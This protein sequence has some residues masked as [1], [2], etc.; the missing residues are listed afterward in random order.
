MTDAEISLAV[1]RIMYP[2]HGW[3]LDGVVYRE[4]EDG[5]LYFFDYRSKDKA[6]G[7]AVWLA[8][9]YHSGAHP[10]GNLRYNAKINSS[11]F[12]SMFE[13]KDPQRALADAIMEVGNER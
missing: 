2:E 8:K 13:T 1:A 4:D 6:F 3:G 7:M 9:Q 11:R 12:R 10:V 5:L